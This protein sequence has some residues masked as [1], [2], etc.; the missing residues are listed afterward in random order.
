MTFDEIIDLDE[1][2]EDKLKGLRLLFVD[3]IHYDDNM[4]VNCFFG[5]EIIYK[6][7]EGYWERYNVKYI[8]ND[9]EV[10]Y[11]REFDVGVV[12][13]LSPD[14]YERVYVCDTNAPIIP[15]WELSN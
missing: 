2:T 15:V 11:T 3:E 12:D 5:V 6:Q 7:S 4:C 9:G 10:E 1:H 14:Y 8:V 13:F